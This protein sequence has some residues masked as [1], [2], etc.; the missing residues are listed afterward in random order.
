MYEPLLAWM[1][2]REEIRKKK[3]SGDPWPWTTDPIFQQYSF[4][5][6]HR[7][8]DKTTV[9]FRENIRDK[10]A[11]TPIDAFFATA[12]FRW[13]NRIETGKVLL[14][15]SLCYFD[16]WS[17]S[18][19]E[20]VLRE[21]GSPW[22]TGAYIIKTPDGKD[23]LDGVIWCVDQFHNRLREDFLT[24]RKLEVYHEWLKRSPF[25]GDFM[26]YEIVTDLRHTAVARDC[27]DIMTWANPGP[28]AMRGINRL[29]GHPLKKKLKK[30]AYIEIMRRILN[31]IIPEWPDESLEMRDIEHSLCEFDKYERVRLGEGRPRSKYIY[32]GK[33]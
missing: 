23:K 11:Y 16:T 8:D 32:P 31:D 26:A 7:E 10:V 5:N 20:Y 17:P 24:S 6:V 12:L 27:V 13:F 19:V 28:G 22:V 21:T 4:T 25:L 9:W 33:R 2:A 30:R 18:Q 14:N 29:L 15:H 1:N 3:E